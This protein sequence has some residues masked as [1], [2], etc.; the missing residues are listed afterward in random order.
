MN[1]LFSS[2]V[3]RVEQPRRAPSA[4][5]Q[6]KVFDGQGTLVARASERAVSVARQATRAV[7]G[8]GDGRRTVHV[9]NAQG[10][11]LLIL[12]K[13][14]GQPSRGTWVS[15]PAG[16]LIGSI[17]PADMVFRLDL[18]DMAERHVGR[19]DGNRLVRK[20]RVLDAQGAHVGQLDKKFKGVA[21]ELLTTADRYSL[22]VYHPLPDPL[23]ILVAVAPLAIDLMHYEGK[24]WPIG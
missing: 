24:D 7:F 22:N 14:G 23:R 10:Q 16:T 13:A 20:F 11:P 5:S 3:L 2:P 1:D 9:E 8:D 18:W 12:D 4:K 6:Y 19:L 17:R 15:D 21:T